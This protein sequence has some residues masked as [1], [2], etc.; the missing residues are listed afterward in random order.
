MAQSKTAGVTP[1]PS[2]IRASAFDAANVPAV[3]AG[4][5]WSRADW[6]RSCETQERLIRAC[7][8]RTT[9]GA[10][11][12]LCYIRFQIAESLEKSG[13]FHLHSDVDAVQKYIDLHLA[14]LTQEAEA[15]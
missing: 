10:D 2:L 15:A 1:L 9:D 14:Y 6:N 3:T 4:R 12:R 5:Q 13:H 11:S 8:G 7:Y